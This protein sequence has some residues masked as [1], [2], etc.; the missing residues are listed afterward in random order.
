MEDVSQVVIGEQLHVLL[1]GSTEA[2]KKIISVGLRE[3]RR[4]SE[5]S[6]VRCDIV[7]LLNGLNNVALTLKLEE[8]LRDHDV[9]VV[10]VD[11]VVAEVAL[12]FVEASGVTESTLVVGNGPL[13]GAHNTEVVVSVGVHGTNE[14]VLGEGG[15]LD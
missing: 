13:G 10:K 7:V 6:L 5:A 15:F 1:A 11:H 4:V 14:G 8:L 9:G 12:V 2:V 3:H